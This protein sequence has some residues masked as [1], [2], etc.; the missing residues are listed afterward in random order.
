[1]RAGTSVQFGDQVPGW[2]DHD[3]I[4]PSR[5]VGRPSREGILRGG[6]PI[7]Y[8]NTA[9]VEVEVECLGFAFA[10]G[11]GCCRF[12][13][14]GEPVQLGELQGAM[15]VC[16]VAKDAAGADRSELLIITNQPDTRTP[17]DGELHGGVE[18]QSVGHAGFIDDHQG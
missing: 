6:G 10:E 17:I 3:C 1:M 8:M 12:G 4:E 14:V 15:R 7:T 11:E 16:D 5:S 9:V 13:G 2:G 18:G